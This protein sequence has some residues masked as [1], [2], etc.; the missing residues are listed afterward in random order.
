MRKYR[1]ILCLLLIIIELSAYQV[2]LPEGQVKEIT[3]EDLSKE[4]LVSFTT[5]RDKDGGQKEETWQGIPLI[6]WL[7]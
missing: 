2:Y 4:K 1:L 3:K 7:N 5:I 6:P